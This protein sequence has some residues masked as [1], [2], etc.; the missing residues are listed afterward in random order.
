MKEHVTNE[1]TIVAF[2]HGKHVTLSLQ[3][4][5]STQSIDISELEEEASRL[6]TETLRG[7]KKKIEKKHG[8]RL[9]TLPFI[10]NFFMLSKTVI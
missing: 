10:G 8:A 9:P 5:I 4:L 7:I 2:R 1:L 3:I 6:R